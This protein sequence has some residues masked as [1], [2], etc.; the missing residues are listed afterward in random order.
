MKVDHADILKKVRKNIKIIE[1]DNIKNFFKEST[2]INQQNKKQPCF[3]CT[4]DGVKM[5]LDSTRNYINKKELLEWYE[6]EKGDKSIQNIILY[7]RKEKYFVDELEEVL[8]AMNVKC[9][10]QYP[11]LTYRIDLFLPKLNIAIE[12]D[13]NE[14]KNY[15]YEKQELRQDNIEK[16]MGCHFIRLSDSESNLHNIGVV[17]ADLMREISNM[18]Q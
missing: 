7:D 1:K 17:M 2:Y 4:L 6:E 13:E 16:E 8:N 10:R 15:S 14:H 11:I 3:I 5:I 12:Y 9:V 18:K